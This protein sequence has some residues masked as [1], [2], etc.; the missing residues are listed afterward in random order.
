M[1]ELIFMMASATCSY[2]KLDVALSEHRALLSKTLI[3][4]TDLE[5]A[6]IV[7]DINELFSEE[8]G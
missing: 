4:H 1:H 2:N 3:I 5:L 6:L 8:V 7:N